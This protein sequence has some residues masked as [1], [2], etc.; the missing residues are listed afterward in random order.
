MN[1]DRASHL[2]GTADGVVYRLEA[3][4][5]AQRQRH[6]PPRQH[7]EGDDRP[8]KHDDR[9]EK[10]EA[11]SVEP[12]HRRRHRRRRGHGYRFCV[13]GTNR[14]DLE[15]VRALRT[16]ICHRVGA[17]PAGHDIHER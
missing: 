11:R 15:Q 10:P 14:G 16:E 2:G 8:A 9:H 6:S 12:L 5:L 7:D 3:W 4:D 17:R 13:I 1:R